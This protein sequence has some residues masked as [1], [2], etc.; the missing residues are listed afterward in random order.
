MKLTKFAA[1]LQDT[2]TAADGNVESCLYLEMTV[3]S[4]DSS[5]ALRHF[6]YECEIIYT[7]LG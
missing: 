4:L 6:S 5:S 3:T 1:I 7:A 2:A